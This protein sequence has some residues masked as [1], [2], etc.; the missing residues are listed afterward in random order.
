MML[1]VQLVHYTESEEYSF[2]EYYLNPDI[3]ASFSSGTKQTVKLNAGLGEFLIGQG[4][5][6]SN[7][8]VI[9]LLTDVSVIALIKPEELDNQLKALHEST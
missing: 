9:E 3:I 1:K 5:S 8:T 4:L 2:L 7:L 6:Y